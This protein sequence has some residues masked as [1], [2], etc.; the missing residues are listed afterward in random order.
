VTESTLPLITPRFV[1]QAKDVAW[2]SDV[3]PRGTHPHQLDLDAVVEEMFSHDEL[4]LTNAVVIIQGGRVLVE[5]YAGV[6]EFFDRPAE[7][8]TASSALLS[9]SMA[10]SMLHLIVGT[11]VDEGRLD[12][13]QFAPVPEWHDDDDPR[14]WIRVR[15]LLAM[16][17][18]LGFVE[19][20]EIGQNSD[21]IEMLFG[22]GKTRRRRLHRARGA[23]PRT[24]HLFQLL[25]CT[26][27]LL[28]RIVADVVGHADA[29]REYLA[30]RLFSPLGMK[31]PWPR[32]TTRA[33]G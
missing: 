3:W 22:E 2:P 16:R 30:R 15:D 33:C 5:R 17:D 11:L 10:K 8:I 14:H 6:M 31:M 7:P 23:R 29:Y 4:A 18:G 13:D 25:Q 24:G 28:S 32:S 26:T 19:E 27:N 1:A 12:P 20:Y 21:V 9:W